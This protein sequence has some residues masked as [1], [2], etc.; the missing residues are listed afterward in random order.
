MRG[1]FMIFF[2]TLCLTNYCKLGCRDSC[3]V[4][5]SLF[6]NKKCDSS[7]FSVT[8]FPITTVMSID[9]RHVVN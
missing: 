9:T 1:S 4:H 6:S 7:F 8:F 5:S 3:S 2:S